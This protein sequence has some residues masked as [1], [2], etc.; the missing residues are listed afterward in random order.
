MSMRRLEEH[1]VARPPS[2]AVA[3]S[4]A[5]H[6]TETAPHPDVALLHARRAKLIHSLVDELSLEVKDW[7]GTDAPHPSEIVD[8][9]VTF[10]PAAIAA[11]AA[12]IAAWITRPGKVPSASEGVLALQLFFCFEE[13]ALS[14]SLVSSAPE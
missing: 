12:I 5:R 14:G 4:V 6:I 7:G 13:R 8:L 3:L 9:V 1:A 2:G 10:G 11:A